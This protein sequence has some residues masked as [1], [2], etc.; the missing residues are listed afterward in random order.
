[1]KLCDVVCDICQKETID[2]PIYGEWKCSFCG[3]YYEYN[4][5]HMIVLSLDQLELL[6]SLLIQKPQI[7]S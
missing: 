6:R 7:F 3:Q 1:M 2:V 4:E 5:G